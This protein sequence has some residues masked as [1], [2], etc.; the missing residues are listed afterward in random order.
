MSI[1]KA[2]ISFMRKYGT[3]RRVK[4]KG[5][6]KRTL[7]HKK[8]GWHY[9]SQ[10]HS[11]ARYGVSTGRKRRTHSHRTA[12]YSKPQFRSA[13][14]F[15][16]GLN[17]VVGVGNYMKKKNEEKKAREQ[18]EKQEKEALE[19]KYDG[20][21][22]KPKEKLVEKIPFVKSFEKIEQ[23]SNYREAQRNARENNLL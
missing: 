22:Q 10:R 21:I 15:K 18:K 5:K 3:T 20:E 14:Y 6:G 7:S 4:H 8:K 12:S 16:A 1:E 13:P 2:S 17:A 11:L 9:E 19:K 23:D